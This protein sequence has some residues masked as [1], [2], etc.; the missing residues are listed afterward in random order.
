[1]ANIVLTHIEPKEGLIDQL[2]QYKK[3]EYLEYTILEEFIL[4]YTLRVPPIDLIDEMKLTTMF[5][6][7]GP[8][9]GETKEGDWF[10]YEHDSELGK[11]VI[12][13]MG[14]N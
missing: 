4:T 12:S 3:I 7:F 5:Y 13:D 9:L 10:E 11:K 14:F 1:M 8:M 6:D 2:E